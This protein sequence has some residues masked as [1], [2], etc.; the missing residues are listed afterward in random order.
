MSFKWIGSALV[1]SAFAFACGGGSGGGGSGVPSNT[2]LVDVTPDQAADLCEYFVNSQEQ[3]E[4][5]IDCGGGQ[6][7]TVG[8]NPED[9]AAQVADCT[10]GLQTD[11]TDG[12]DV[13]VGQAEDCFD[14]LGA[15]TDAQLCDPNG[16]LPAA[17][18]PLFTN[19]ACG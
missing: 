18:A 1:C 3:P 17:C 4:R 16:T 8:I 12:C 7:I 11:V 5:T 19:D 10:S 6:T 15:L 9:V 14:A 13:T 2:L